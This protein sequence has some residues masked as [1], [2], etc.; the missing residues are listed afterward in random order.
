MDS[1]FIKL[2]SYACNF[3]L[4]AL[5]NNLFANLFDFHI[6]DLKASVDRSKLEIMWPSMHMHFLQISLVVLVFS[7]I[8]KEVCLA[9]NIVLTAHIFNMLHFKEASWTLN[10]G[11]TMIFIIIF[12]KGRFGV[13]FGYQL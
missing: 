4:D 6:L 7:I 11:I 10:Y 9:L 5:G 12:I 3:K 1:V 13:A 2:F 8:Y